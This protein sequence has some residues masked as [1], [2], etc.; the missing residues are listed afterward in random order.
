[1]KPEHQTGA[2]GYG[3]DGYGYAAHNS[4]AAHAHYGD[5]NDS[6]TEDSTTVS[7][8]GSLWRQSLEARRRRLMRWIDS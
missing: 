1:M 8:P 7:A 6:E 2:Y 3:Q 4:A 5:G